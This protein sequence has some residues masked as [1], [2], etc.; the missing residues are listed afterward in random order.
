MEHEFQPEQIKHKFFTPWVIVI[1]VIALIGLGFL[2]MRFI[3]GLGFVTK[4]NQFFLGNM[5][6]TGCSNR[7]PCAGGFTTAVLVIYGIVINTK[8]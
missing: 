1:S 4:L 5:D 2:A 3:F 8:C 6:R 7:L